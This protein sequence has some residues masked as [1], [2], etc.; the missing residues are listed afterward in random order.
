LHHAGM[1]FEVVATP[2]MGRSGPG[3]LPIIWP[4]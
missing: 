3:R 1:L 2:G 4:V